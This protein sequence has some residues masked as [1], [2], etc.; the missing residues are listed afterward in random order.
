MVL[1]D[2]PPDAPLIDSSIL[3]ESAPEKYFASSLEDISAVAVPVM[4]GLA[5][6]HGKPLE[7]VPRNGHH[8]DGSFLLV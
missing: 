2:P 8:Y 7:R 3:S 5:K 1:S 4:F 6:H